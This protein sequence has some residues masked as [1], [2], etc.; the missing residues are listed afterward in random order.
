MSWE[1]KKKEM[2][3]DE[4]IEKWKVTYSGI[5]VEKRKKRTLKKAGREAK[6]IIHASVVKKRVKERR[7]LN[8]T[9]QKKKG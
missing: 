3:G 5:K 9:N 7:I 6:S 8:C 4:N 2:S 1:R